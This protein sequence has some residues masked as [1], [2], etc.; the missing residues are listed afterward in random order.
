MRKN[1]EP[2]IPVLKVSRERR[3]QTNLPLS[4]NPRAAPP[5]LPAHPV[6]ANMR[7]G[8]QATGQALHQSKALIFLPVTYSLRLSQINARANR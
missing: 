8:Y 3:K 1:R 4:A 7:S 2:K 6:T 5:Q